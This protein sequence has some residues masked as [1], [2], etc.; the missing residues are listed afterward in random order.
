M[1]RARRDTF[2]EVFRGVPI[3]SSAP[4]LEITRES[5]RIA[6]RRQDRDDTSTDAREERPPLFLPTN[7][8]ACIHAHT[9]GGAIHVHGEARTR[10]FQ[11]RVAASTKGPWQY[12][13]KTESN[14]RAERDAAQEGQ[15]GSKSE[16]RRVTVGDPAAGCRQHSYNTTR[17]HTSCTIHTI[18]LLRFIL[19]ILVCFSRL[20]PFRG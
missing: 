14:E 12:S 18:R 15:R 8:C 7:M 20:V 6:R 19:C 16:S 1:K 4:P 13:F 10:R 5:W 9:H 17:T 3:E 2:R 11:A